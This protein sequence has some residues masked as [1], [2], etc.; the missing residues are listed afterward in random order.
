[1]WMRERTCSAGGDGGGLHVQRRLGDVNEVAVKLDCSPKTVRRLADA[2]KVPGR[3]R[4]GRL[5][6]FDLYVIDQWIKQGCPPL[7]RFAKAA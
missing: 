7:H 4:L 1:M 2:G 6:K 3:V 5:V